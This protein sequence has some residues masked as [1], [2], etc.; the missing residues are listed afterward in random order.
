[1]N[2][3]Y[4]NGEYLPLAEAKISVMDRGFLFGDGVYEVIPV[5]NGKIFR[6]EQHIA[7]LKRSLLGISLDCSLELEDWQEI[8]NTLLEANDSFGPNQSIYLQI[9]R[10]IGPYRN[11]AFPD[12][13]TPTILVLTNPLRTI[14]FEQLQKG[15][16]AITLEDTRWQW[17]HIKSIALLANVLLYQAALNQECAE[18]ILIKDGFALEGATSNLFIV[19]KG[20]IITPPLS[21][22]IL[23]GVTRDLILLL[24][25]NND[26]PCQ[27]T[28]IS[29]Q[30][31]FE[32]DEVWITSSTR[33][34]YPIIKIN[35]QQIGTGRPGEIWQRMI[36]KYHDFIRSL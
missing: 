10:G 8:I 26:M 9:T 6:F 18:T 15:M 32:A 13:G 14:P 4:L 33:E 16:C 12:H 25:K 23:G 30:E 28:A 20:N 21:S 19:K 24:A 35:N 36:A 1:M 3:V 27:E 17:C 11:H 5:Y 29:E 31:L 22:R 2:T 34:I 7:R